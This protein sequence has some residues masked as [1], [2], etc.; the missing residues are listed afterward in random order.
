MRSGDPEPVEDLKLIIETKRHQPTSTVDVVSNASAWLKAALKGAGVHF[1]YS[2][3]RE[4][5]YGYAVMTL[6]RSHRGHPVSLDLKIAEIQNRPY[7]FAEVRSLG[8]FGGTMFPFFSDMQSDDSRE[9]LLHYISDFILSTE[10]QQ[11]P[12]PQ[13]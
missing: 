9:L 5:H 11:E 3:C 12:S 10:H 13:A 8:R 7:V 4:E 2:A 1:S 6:L